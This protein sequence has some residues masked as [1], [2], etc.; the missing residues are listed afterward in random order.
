MGLSLKHTWRLR[1]SNFMCSVSCLKGEGLKVRKRLD[2][3]SVHISADAKRVPLRVLP[4]GDMPITVISTPGPAKGGK[5]V[6]NFADWSCPLLSYVQCTGEILCSVES[7]EEFLP[8]HAHSRPSVTAGYL[9]GFRDG[10]STTSNSTMP[11]E[12]LRYD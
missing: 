9:L 2:Y 12:I 4:S 3:I 10:L 5:C 1:G 6:S 7:T 8:P 11:I